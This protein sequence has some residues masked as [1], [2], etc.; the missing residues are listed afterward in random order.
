MDEITIGDKTYI[1]SKRAAKITGYAKDYVGQ[2]CREGRVEARLVGRSWYVLE[3]AIREHRF[4][5]DEEEVQEEQK[6]AEPAFVWAT[7][8]YRSEAPV[9]V[10]DISEVAR[11]LS[12]PAIADMQAAWKEWFE[13]KRPLQQAAATG[14]PVEMTMSVTQTVEET[15]SVAPESE[16]A[17]EDVSTP[18]LKEALSADID[19]LTEIEEEEIVPIHK[20]RNH[21]QIRSSATSVDYMPVAREE[22]RQIVPPSV[23][24]KAEESQREVQ[25]QVHAIDTLDEE[26]G[27][28]GIT[29][30]LFIVLAFAAVCVAIVG[31]GNA[32]RLFSGSSVDFGFQKDIIKY[33]DGTSTY[34]STL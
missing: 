8:S 28:S 25:A 20:A 7:P 12:A 13:E 19:S 5:K 23:A 29:R 27:A 3:A 31:T 14:E 24:R 1:S 30:A 9:S 26:Q 10:P 21:D 16:A 17:H 32:N 34:E 18:V 6:P 15:F 33:L 11:P 2:L 22:Q 4:G